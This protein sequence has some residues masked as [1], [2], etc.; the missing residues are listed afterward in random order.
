MSKNTAIDLGA[1]GD[2]VDHEDGMEP[3]NKSAAKMSKLYEQLNSKTDEVLAVT[4]VAAA[5]NETLLKAIPLIENLQKQVGTLEQ[6]KLDLAKRM[7]H[8]EGQPLAR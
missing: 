6:E 2:K 3:A 7:E 5:S 1:K 4:K 8:L